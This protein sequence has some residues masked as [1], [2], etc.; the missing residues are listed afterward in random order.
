VGY[1][2]G[3]TA[4]PADGKAITQKFTHQGRDGLVAGSPFYVVYRTA[5]TAI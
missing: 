4:K 3:E 2:E 1:V 5:D